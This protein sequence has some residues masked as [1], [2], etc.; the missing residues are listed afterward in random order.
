[1]ADSSLPSSVKKEE[2]TNKLYEKLQKTQQQKQQQK[3]KCN[4]CRWWP[5]G[6]GGA[7]QC[8]L[9]PLCHRHYA[10]RIHD[11]DLKLPIQQFQLVN[12]SDDGTC[13]YRN[14]GLEQTN[15]AKETQRK[16]CRYCDF[17]DKYTLQ[18]HGLLISSYIIS[19]RG[20]APWRVQETGNYG[21]WHENRDVT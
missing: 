8:Q 19:V 4:T 20:T 16:K 9:L 6:T 5:G 12:L 3:S 10:S 11:L 17:Y 21:S 14:V 1:M 2:K 13:L 15:H 18:A 7:A